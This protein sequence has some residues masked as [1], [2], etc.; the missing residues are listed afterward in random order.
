MSFDEYYRLAVHRV[1]PTVETLTEAT[2]D[3]PN[4]DLAM[5]QAF[6][7]DRELFFPAP[8]SLRQLL[9][10]HGV[11]QTPRIPVAAPRLDVVGE[12]CGVFCVPS[13]RQG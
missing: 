7:T 3:V 9:S 12:R 8:V 11:P 5:E 13:D 10:I 6:L 1:K 2:W 4:C